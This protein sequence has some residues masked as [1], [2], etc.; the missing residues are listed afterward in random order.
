[1]CS[2]FGTNAPLSLVDLI[3]EAS[4]S[5]NLQQMGFFFE[6]MDFVR[7]KIPNIIHLKIEGNVFTCNFVFCY[8]GIFNAFFSNQGN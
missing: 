8:Q 5:D 3:N 7:I 4:T 2:I 1:M 6:A